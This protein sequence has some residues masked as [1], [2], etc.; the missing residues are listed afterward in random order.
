MAAPWASGAKL[1]IIGKLHGQDCINV[2][3]FGTNTEILDPTQL[4]ELLTQLATAMLA[5]VVDSLLPAVTSNYTILRV[6]ASQLHPV[7]GDVI[8]VAAAP[9]SVGA[10][11]PVSASFIATLVNVKTGFGGRSKRGKMF[12]PPVGEAE[13]T[14]SLINAGNMDEII[15]FLTCVAGKFIG[16]GATEFWRLGVYSKKLAGPAKDFNLGFTEALNLVPSN[17]LAKMGSR[18]V[19]RGS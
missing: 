16:A 14:D 7:K 4:A 19:G 5:C 9:G 1:R 10:L 3:H 6:E 18:K 12:L 11:S 8:E 13:A 2:L 15:A 17:V